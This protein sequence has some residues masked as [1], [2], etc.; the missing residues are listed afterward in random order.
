MENAWWTF[1][2]NFEAPFVFLIDEAQEE[3][4]FGHGDLYLRRIEVHSNT[5]IELESWFTASGQTR[6]TVVG[7]FRAKQWLMH[8]IWS[9]GSQEAH[10][11]ARGQEMLLRVQNQPLTRADLDDSLR[12]QA[13]DWGLSPV[14][15]MKGTT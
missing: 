1:P 11:H 7:P 10:H 9:L 6:V 8:M 2:E 15:R 4:I 12:V 13:Y 3:Q 14:I 5:F